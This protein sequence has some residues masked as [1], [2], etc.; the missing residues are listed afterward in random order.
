MMDSKV[1]AAVGM[2]RKWDA[3]EAGREVA[4]TA[5]KKLS[6]PPSFFLLFSTIHYEKYGGFQEFLNGVWDVMPKETP[7]VGGTVT[8]FINNYG[9]FSR[10]ASAL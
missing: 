5:I 6:E 3:R 10:G 9:C 7:L 1:E 4:E 2:S 8:G